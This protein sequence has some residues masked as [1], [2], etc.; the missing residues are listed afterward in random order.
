MALQHA[1]WASS[2]NRGGT[3][4]DPEVFNALYNALSENEKLSQYPEICSKIAELT[5]LNVKGVRVIVSSKRIAMTTEE[6]EEIITTIRQHV[7]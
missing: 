3:K 7:L 6:V 5:P 1:E 2:A 4:T